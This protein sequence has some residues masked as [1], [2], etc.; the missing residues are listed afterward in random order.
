MA[1]KVLGNST[2][3]PGV[4]VSPMPHDYLNH[5]IIKDWN[6]VRP[7]ILMSL[8]WQSNLFYYLIYTR[9]AK[10]LN[11]RNIELSFWSEVS[12]DSLNLESKTAKGK[13]TKT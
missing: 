13:N 2:G 3:D 10:L 4:H 6:W 1:T 5:L 12:H 9:K 11:L 7:L 8:V